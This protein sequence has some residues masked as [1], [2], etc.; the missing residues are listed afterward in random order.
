MKTTA[1]VTTAVVCLSMVAAC[2]VSATPLE[3]G[4]LDDESR[5]KREKAEK[6][7]QSLGMSIN[8]NDEDIIKIGAGYAVDEH[9]TVE[10]DV[11]IIGGGLTVEGTIGGDA[12][13]IGGSMYLAST[14]VI[15]GDAVVIG[16]ILEMEDG[17]TVNGEI[18]ENP[19]GSKM[20]A[21]DYYEQM[22]ELEELEGDIVKFADDIYIDEDEVVQGDVVAIGGDIIVEGTVV[23]NVV[24]TGGDILLGGDAEVQGDVAATF[25]EVTV[26]PG[27]IIDGDVIEIDLG[28]AHAVPPPMPKKLKKPIPPGEQVTYLISL[29]RPEADEIRLTGSWIDW[30][31]EG[32]R[33]KRDKK[34][35]WKTKVALGPGMHTYKFIVDGKWIADPDID[36]KVP[37]GMGG[38]AT[39][40]LVKG[41]GMKPKK[42]E[43]DGQAINF[44]LDRPGLYD[45]RVTGDW[46][47]WDYEGIRMTPGKSGKW[48]VQIALPAGMRVYK[49]Y[50]N[51]EWVPDP[52]VDKVVEDRM[53]GY[54]T[55]FVVQPRS[56]DKTVI[57]FTHDRPDVDDMRI[58]GS[59]NDWDP[60]GI[61]M[62]KGEEGVWFTYLA[63]EPGA[64]EYKFYIDGDWVADPDSP[65][66][67]V[68]DGQGDYM[69][70]FKVRPPRKKGLTVRTGPK[71][72]KGFDGMFDY[73]RV[74]GVYLGAQLESEGFTHPFPNFHLDGGYSFKRKR[75]GYTFEI[76]Q[77]LTPAFMLSVGGSMYDRTD[78][79]DGELITDEE[80]LIVAS[81][82]KQD[83]KDYFDR[84]GMTGFAALRP[85]EGH[86]FK[87]SYT[88]DDYRPLEKKVHTALFRKD[89]EFRP[90][91]RNSY[92]IGYDPEIGAMITR[93]I[94][95]E[96][97]TVSYELNSFDESC[98]PKDKGVWIRLNGEWSDKEWGSDM[99]YSRYS[100]DIRKYHRFTP[101]QHVALRLMG[102]LLD[103][104]EECAC[105]GI[106]D[107]QYFFPKQF[108]V[109]G[110]GTLPGY[111]YKQFQ[112]THMVLANLEYTYT[113]KGNLSVV[114]FSDAGDAKGIVPREEW[115]KDD[116][117]DEISMKFDAGVAFRH[118]EPGE[119]SITLG[120]AK[121]LTKLYDD[122]ERPVIVTV[123][124]S[125][126]F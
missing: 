118:E 58:T 3:F 5:E 25:G 24:T 83:Y 94:E 81:L 52:D 70:R 12:A 14:A 69:T 85:W 30:D 56:K 21:E 95:I 122:D 102:G 60:Y 23:G 19:E 27:A 2:L 87:V 119:H 49:F 46:M 92:Q 71:A 62:Y 37:D 66:K 26:E 35:T 124:A 117:W 121:G 13:V 18:V 39:P 90:N 108:A 88:S 113:I 54:A 22:E 110:I 68:P 51:D 53:G 100:A 97:V 6:L 107:P 82:L 67:R 31:P 57:K 55:A 10:G 77:P 7:M 59:F 72:G 65:E 84:R 61:P 89:D 96:A 114:F 103:I 44:S 42:S 120:V 91:P 28:G 106:P 74:D 16:G 17:A 111:G 29:N 125:R 43:I 32:I 38:W 20:Y 34:G 101:S 9:E 64:H 112:G 45:V 40:L 80:N 105:P 116:I 78:S 50:V 11:V 1:L 123:R 99:N 36:E 93:K 48:S 33:M 79:Y 115:N 98:C 63:L 86:T 73:N 47:D 4:S 41:K 76:D 126:P 15:E 8:V 75:W 104:G 109:G